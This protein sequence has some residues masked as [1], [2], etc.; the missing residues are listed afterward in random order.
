MYGEKEDDFGAEVAE[1]ACQA[2]ELFEGS[3]GIP[4]C[5]LAGR[6]S[7]IPRSHDSRTLLKVTI[8]PGPLVRDK[9][10]V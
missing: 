3:I 2:K 10:K 6:C 7:Y 8:G 5:Q 9:G 1:V 4:S